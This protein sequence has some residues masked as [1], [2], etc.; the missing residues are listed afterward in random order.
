MKPTYYLNPK[1]LRTYILWLLGAK[2]ILYIRLLGYFEPE[3][4]GPYA[5]IVYT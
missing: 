5:Q 4:K 1:A 2:T 3:G